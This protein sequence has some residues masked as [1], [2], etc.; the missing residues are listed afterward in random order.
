MNNEICAPLERIAADLVRRG[1]P[2]EYAQ[3]A[4]AELGDHHGDLVGQLRA[5]GFDEQ[6]AD[7]EASRR[8]GDSRTLVNKTVREYQRR[9]WCGR[10]PLLTFLLGPIVL[11][12]LSFVAIVLL[13]YCIFVPLEHLGIR[14]D[15]TPDGIRS[16]SENV[17]AIVAHVLFLVVAPAV[18]L[19]ILARLVRKAAMGSAWLWLCT[20]IMAVFASCFWMGFAGDVRANMPADQ[21]LTILGPPMLRFANDPLYVA[22]FLL[23]LSI[24]AGMVLRMRRQSRRAELT[25]L[26]VHSQGGIHEYAKCA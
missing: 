3:R 24:G 15:H 17:A 18:S 1:L 20:G 21:G 12:V 23:P 7:A 4:A 22:Q 16:T 9:F 25:M 10:W 6:A 14:L 26:E 19:L 11:A 2:I 5:G 13:A 8:L